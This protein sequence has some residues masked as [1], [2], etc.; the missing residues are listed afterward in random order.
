MSKPRLLLGFMLLVATPLQAQMQYGQYAVVDGDEIYVSEVG[1]AGSGTIYIYVRSGSGWA[2]TGTLKAPPVSGHTAVDDYFGRAVV[3]DGNQLIV[4]STAIDLNGDDSSDGM[5]FIFNRVGDRWEYASELRPE[6]IPSGVSYGRF[7]ALEDDHLFITE[8]GDNGG[9]GAVWVFERDGAAGWTSTQKL[10]PPEDTSQGHFFGWGLAANGGRL[11][12]GTTN[13]SGVAYIFARG[14]D[15]AWKRETTLEPDEGQGGFGSVVGWL[16]D[17]AL[18]G[19]PGADN[20]LGAVHVYERNNMTGNWST[21]V[22]LTAYDRQPGG[23]FGGFLRTTDDEVWIG[24]PGADGAGRIYIFDYDDDGFG[25][26]RKLAGIDPDTGDGFGGF[27][28]TGDRY[29]AI[30]QLAD[31]FGLGSVILMSQ[32]GDGW[33]TDEKVMGPTPAALEAMTNGEI[34]CADG[35]ADR[36]GCSQVDVLSFLPVA[37]IGGGRGATTNDVWGWTDAQTGREY[38]LVGRTDGTA[39]IDVMNPES[40]VFLGNLAKTPG[41]RGNAWRDIKVYADH[42]FIVADGAGNHGMQVFDLTRLRDVRNAPVEFEPDALYDGIASAHNIV[43][44]ESIGYAYA[45]G[46]HSGER[47]AGVVST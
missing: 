26:A 5:V 43:I 37:D 30:G 25:D 27:I 4:G 9:R 38:A 39:F 15:G 10:A 3:R 44:N 23:R 41:S 34:E 28:A 1:T 14:A 47:P 12:V 40:P 29:A 35:S 17:R 36:Y 45:V 42:A 18:V 2:Q 46:S 11:I 6:S 22:T 21:S 24:A 7:M 16:G 13:G 32:S 8:L 19:A 31:D 33:A 20:G